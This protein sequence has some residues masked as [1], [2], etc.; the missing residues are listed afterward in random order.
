MQTLKSVFIVSSVYLVF[1]YEHLIFSPLSSLQCKCFLSVT[2]SFFTNERKLCLDPRNSFALICTK[3][4]MTSFSI[5]FVTELRLFTD[6]KPSDWSKE[7][8]SRKFH[9]AFRRMARG[10]IKHLYGKSCKN[11]VLCL[12]IGGKT[13]KHLKLH[14]VPLYFHMF[15]CV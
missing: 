9:N 14:V 4:R 1:Y 6:F 7:K 11:D 12:Y 13:G 3:G 15:S 8:L 5:N 2:P 10:Y